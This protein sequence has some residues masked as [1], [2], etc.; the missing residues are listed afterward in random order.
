MKDI[1]KMQGSTWGINN[2][3]AYIANVHTCTIGCKNLVVSLVFIFR[4]EFV[5]FSCDVCDVPPL[6]ED[7]QS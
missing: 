5:K 2:S 6:N 7:S 4:G 3:M 1:V